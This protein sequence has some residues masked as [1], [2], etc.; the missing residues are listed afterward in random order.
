[1]LTTDRIIDDWPER[2]RAQTAEALC[3]RAA[4]AALRREHARRRAHGMI[5]RN[6]G[7]LADARDRARR[8]PDRVPAP[9]GRDPTGGPRRD[10][11]ADLGGG[12][13][14]AA[15]RG[16]AGDADPVTT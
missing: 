5:D 13:S 3:R 14:A 7:R 16:S 9:P 12:R 4:R 8:P 15:S 6:A 1:M 11:P 2:F 10:V